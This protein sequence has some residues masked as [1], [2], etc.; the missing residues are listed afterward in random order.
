MKKDYYFSNGEFVIENY[1]RQKTFSS[2]LTAIAGKKG[3]LSSFFDA[4]EVKIKI[5]SIKTQ[6]IFIILPLARRKMTKV[7]LFYLLWVM[8]KYPKFA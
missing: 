8:G 4:Q 7:H 5:T 2:F 1:D 3:V 6:V